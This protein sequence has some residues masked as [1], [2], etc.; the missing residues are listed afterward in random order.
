VPI[1]RIASRPLRTALLSQC[2]LTAAMTVAAGLL[3]GRH[4]ALSAF[5]GAGVGV[6]ASVTYAVVVSRSTAQTARDAVRTMFRAEAGKLAVLVLLLWTVLT[7]YQDVVHAAL[8]P[9]FVVTVLVFQ[10]AFFIRDT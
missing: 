2:A 9:A 3:Y 8:F 4:A 7:F 5:C 1:L 10:L 6:A